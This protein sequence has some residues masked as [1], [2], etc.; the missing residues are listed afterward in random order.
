[1]DQIT[2]RSGMRTKRNS[3]KRDSENSTKN[4]DI[5]DRV[6]HTPIIAMENG[7]L[8]KVTTPVCAQQY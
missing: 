8:N 5:K 2:T 6:K 3:E 4:T 1:M 7:G